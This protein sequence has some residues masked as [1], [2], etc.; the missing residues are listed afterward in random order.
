MLLAW[1][2]G[3]CNGEEGL[4]QKSSIQSI[5]HRIIGYIRLRMSGIAK[6]PKLEYLPVK[7]TLS[8]SEL[9]NN[10]AM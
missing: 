6:F 3:T 5:M 7:D 1:I 9:W 10:P 2:K 4:G 8:L